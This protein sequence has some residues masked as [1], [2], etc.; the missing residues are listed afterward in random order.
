MINE[1]TRIPYVLLDAHSRLQSLVLTHNGAC[2]CG[3]PAS[4]RENFGTKFD[5]G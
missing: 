1:S 2:T 3:C 4:V 5:A